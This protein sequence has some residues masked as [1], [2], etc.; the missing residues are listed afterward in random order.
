MS[1]IS[2]FAP[3][4]EYVKSEMALCAPTPTE[5]I[6]GRTSDPFY[7][8]V[9]NEDSEVLCVVRSDGKMYASNF[10]L[11]SVRHL[12]D[13]KVKGFEEAAVNELLGSLI[14]KMERVDTSVDA[15]SS[16]L[17]ELFWGLNFVHQTALRAIE[18]DVV[19]GVVP[20]DQFF[21]LATSLPSNARHVDSRTDDLFSGGYANPQRVTL[22]SD[23][24]SFALNKGEDGTLSWITETVFTKGQEVEVVQGPFGMYHAKLP[25]KGTIGLLPHLDLTPPPR[26]AQAPQ[27]PSGKR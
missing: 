3:L 12:D 11:S 14:A 4:V 24:Q 21:E 7:V 17:E 8:A 10:K 25:L 13:L 18:P 1:T 26:P 27:A 22:N 9:F 5:V 2:K 16:Q 23:I 15:D 6:T 20:F 19:E